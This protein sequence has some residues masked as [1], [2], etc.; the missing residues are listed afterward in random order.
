VNIGKAEYILVLHHTQKQE[1]PSNQTVPT[2]HVGDTI[3]LNNTLYC[4][5]PKHDLQNR[6][7]IAPPTT[8]ACALPNTLTE[9][10]THPMAHQHNHS[11]K[12]DQDPLHFL[13]PQHANNQANNAFLHPSI[14]TSFEATSTRTLIPCTQ[15]KQYSTL[16]TSQ[17]L[18]HKQVIE[19]PITSE[20]SR[21]QS[22]T[23]QPIKPFHHRHEEPPVE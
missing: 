8:W 22:K 21:P 11:V 13:Y 4:I 1:T 17:P 7:Q 6:T 12:I 10:N 20:H 14:D 18:N 23:M 16:E 19:L 9:S 15:P 3:K 5:E 2:L